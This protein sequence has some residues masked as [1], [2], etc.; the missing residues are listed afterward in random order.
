MS[1]YSTIEKYIKDAQ[2]CKSIAYNHLAGNGATAS[3]EARLCSHY[4][5]KHALCVDSA[6]NGLL[7]LLLATDLQRKEIITTPLTW[8]GTIAGALSMG[9]KFHF[10]DVDKRTLN[11]SPKSIAECL[12]KNK[13]IKAV[14]AVDFAGNPHDTASIHKICEKFGIWH[15]VD[16]AQSMGAIY[17]GINPIELCD[18]MV[19]SFGSGKVVFGG[20]GGAI[21]TNNSDLYA[22]LLSICQ[23]PHRQER[24]C[25]IGMSTELALN[26]RIHPLAAIMAN[27]NFESGLVAID[28]KR[29]K[30]KTILVQLGMLNSVSTIICHQNG[31]FYHSLFFAENES[32]LQSEFFKSS[33]SNQFGCRKTS[34]VPLPNQICRI[35]KRT[36]IKTY[37]N[38]FIEATLSKLYM[39]TPK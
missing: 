13:K 7:Y 18:A 8:G 25:G 32:V 29:K 35:G 17:D 31:T 24:D 14:I 36:L 21:I 11:I 5:A 34:F 4:G 9:C 28:E 38:P 22:K 3:L 6:T 20:E 12:Q 2:S 33:L 27:E 37:N 23:H 1:T 26:G 15:F 39:L 30:M 16:A 19:V 10:A